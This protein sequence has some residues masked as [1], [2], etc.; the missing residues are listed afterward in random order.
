MPINKFTTLLDLARQAKI[1]TGETATFDG[2]IQ[3]GLPFS[4]YTTG[5]DTGSTV[6]LGIVSSETA[7]FSGDNITTIFDVSNPSSPNYSPIYSGYTAFTWTNPLFSATT[8]GLTLP[9]T[10][11]DTGTQVLGPYWTLTQT[12]TTG[13]YNIGLQYTG[14]S[15]TYSFNNVSF[16]TTATTL[17]S[18]FTT[19]TQENFSAGTLDYKGPLDYISSKEDATV[20]GRL[21]TNKIKITD[22]ASAGSIGY[23]LT[24]SNAEGE[25]MWQSFSAATNN[26]VTGGTLVNADLILGLNDGSTASPIDLSPLS[27]G[28]FTGNTSGSCITDLYITNLYGCSPITIHDSI[29]HNGS[30]AS[31]TLSNAFGFET[32]A[33]TFYSF[34]EGFESVA[35][36]VA[37]HAEGARSI[38][39]GDFSHA[40]GGLLSSYN[41]ASGEGSHAE[42]GGTFAIGIVSHAQNAA[43][44]AATNYSHSQGFFTLSSGDTSHSQGKYTTSIGEA[45]HAEGSGTTSSGIA[46]HSEGYGTTA[47]GDYSHAEGSGTTASGIVSHAEGVGTSATTSYSHAEGILTLSSGIGSHVEGLLNIASGPSS[48]A[49]GQSTTASGNGGA[50]SEGNNTTASGDYSHAEGGSTTASGVASHAE[51]QNTTASGAT[52][53]AEGNN[54]TASGDY[55]HAEGFETLSL[56]DGCHSE[57]YQTTATTENSHSEGYQTIASNSA[58][59]AE[60]WGTTASGLR[61]HSEGYLTIASGDNSHAEGKNTTASN[62]SSHAEGSGTIASGEFSHA[63]GFETTASANYN[64]AEG[65]RT[66]S[67]GL[68]SSHSE[69]YQTSATTSYSHSEGILTLASGFGGHAE[70]SGTTASGNYSHSQ[71]VNTIASGNYSHSGG[72]VIGNGNLVSSGLTSFTHFTVTGSST[73]G[74]FSDYSA[75]LGGVNNNIDSLSNNSV[76]IGGINNRIADSIPNT[77]II[78]GNGIT[79]SSGDTVYVPNLNINSL[80]TSGSFTNIGLDSNKNLITGV[81]AFNLVTDET[82]RDTTYPSPSDNFQVYNL[83][84]DSI[85]T[86]KSDFGLWLSNGMFVGIEN[87]SVQDV[88]IRHIVYLTS[89]GETINGNEYPVVDYASSTS[90]RNVT[91]GVIVE[92][93]DVISGTSNFVS[94]A[95][96]G[97]YYIDYSAT[98]TIGDNVYSTT[99]TTGLANAGNFANAGTIGKAIENSGSNPSF[100][101]SVLVQLTQV[102]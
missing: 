58:S 31:G 78:G 3:V 70:G 39:S 24:Q 26:F 95:H 53:H 68:E 20:D 91:G 23:I 4:A 72:A 93:G 43:T 29:Q 15:I 21:T 40:E 35:S 49:E 38:A 41:T 59:H 51:G 73:Y 87:T 28:T 19:A 8:S 75:I 65:Y 100:T 32:S 44:T 64:H 88:D 94:V 12:G 46:S 1:L 76:I 77:I 97:K 36:G 83:R 9:I 57:G 55:S 34:S 33:T 79:A 69:G 47:S 81:T 71:G 67:S 90:E 25:G 56:G 13:D 54:T 6:S 92:I 10:V 63:E 11:L 37:S 2:K 45:S 66:L 18:G 80:N 86:Y 101:G 5:V 61:S 98:V 102:R 84:T 85:E 74:A 89:S 14:Y 62:Q 99:N 7:I 96:F 42:G 16:E 50:H 48:H 17:Y 30:T 60:G 52:S 22:G 82:D 27:G